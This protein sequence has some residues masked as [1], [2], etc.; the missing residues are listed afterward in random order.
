MKRLAVLCSALFITGTLIFAQ[1]PTDWHP[2]LAED[3]KAATLSDTTNFLV[4]ML[5][6]DEAY[7]GYGGTYFSVSD[8]SMRD[9]CTLH[10]VQRSIGKEQTGAMSGDKRAYPAWQGHPW[11]YVADFQLS[12][13][14][15]LLLSVKKSPQTPPDWFFVSVTGTSNTTVISGK[16]SVYDYDGKGKR[17]GGDIKQA[18]FPCLPGDPKH[19]GETIY[20]ECEE[21]SFNSE[22]WIFNFTNEEP[23]KRFARGLMHASLLCGGTKAVSPF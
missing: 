20:G 18:M 13:V 5:S 11:V 2:N 19:H 7:V 23:A 6:S 9:R 4:S 12:K 8:V 21:G 3:N 16:F 15:P 14:D 22:R 1:Q 17:W 10:F